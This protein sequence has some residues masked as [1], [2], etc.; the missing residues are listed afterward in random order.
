MTIDKTLDV[1]KEGYTLSIRN[2]QII[3]TGKD[4]A[5]L[6]YGYQSLQQLMDDATEQGLRLPTCDIRDFPLLEY[7][8]VH[9]D[10][11]HHMEQWDYYYH[12]IDQLASYK[13]NAIIVELEDKIKYKSQPTIAAKDAKT[14]EQWR[15]LSDYALKKHIRISPLVQGLGHVSFILKHP[16]YH[17]LRDNPKSD[18]AFNPLD[19]TTYDVQFDL[20][21]EA[22]QALPHGN[23]LHVGGD[24]V[25]TTGRNSGKSTLELQLYWLNKVSA[26]AKEHNRIPIV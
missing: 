14:I 17:H 8:P 6:F 12:I 24:E 4:Q 22:F 21:R 7:R 18:W 13:V 26:F 25:H 5:G 11:K 23:Y 9:L 19:S 1:K 16:E 20:Y 2:D 10:V 15:E 3:I